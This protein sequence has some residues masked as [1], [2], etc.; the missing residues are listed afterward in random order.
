MSSED[1]IE[2]GQTIQPNADFITCQTHYGALCLFFFFD[3]T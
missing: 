3:F 2:E 1:V